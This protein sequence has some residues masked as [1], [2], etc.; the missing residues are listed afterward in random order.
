MAYKPAVYQPLF[1][2]FGRLWL[3]C[4][5]MLIYSRVLRV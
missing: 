2:R 5:N 3:L 1:C 4:F